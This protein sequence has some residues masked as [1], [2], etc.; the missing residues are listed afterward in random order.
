M[1]P[2]TSLQAAPQLHQS[3]LRV[4][5]NY[6]LPRVGGGLVIPAPGIAPLLCLHFPRVT[7]V[8]Q[9]ES[10]LGRLG[11]GGPHLQGGSGWVLVSLGAASPHPPA[12]ASP[13]SLATSPACSPGSC[14]FLLPTPSSSPPARSTT[15][16]L[17]TATPS[18]CPCSEQHPAHWMQPV[19]PPAAPIL[20][21][22]CTPWHTAEQFRK[23]KRFGI[24]L[25]PLSFPILLPEL[26][27]PLTHPC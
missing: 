23:E 24:L 18:R 5:P 19:T 1:K 8:E 21:P 3:S 14:L 17:Q 2:R 26:L 12:C 11:G 15:T 16:P 27:T 7:V 6:S 10:I 22:H 25:T 4:C 20:T 9:R 13:E